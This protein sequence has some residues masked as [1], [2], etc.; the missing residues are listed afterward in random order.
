GDLRLAS[1]TRSAHVDQRHLG[2][3][4]FLRRTAGV[5]DDGV[6]VAPPAEVVRKAEPERMQ[7][8][9]GDTKQRKPKRSRLG[10]QRRDLAAG[11][12]VVEV[13]RP[14][15]EILVERRDNPGMRWV[16]TIDARLLRAAADG[17]RDSLDDEGLPVG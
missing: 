15:R 17:D 4:V 16:E 7:L 13:D 11:G 1:L 14:V 12:R 10:D 8:A 2:G 5:R 6:T 3:V 9:V